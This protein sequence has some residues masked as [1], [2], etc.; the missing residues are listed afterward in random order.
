MVKVHAVRSS[1]FQAAIL[2]SKSHDKDLAGRTKPAFFITIVFEYIT[3]YLAFTKA[4]YLL[5]RKTLQT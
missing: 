5:K 2:E 1:W 4:M 3:Q